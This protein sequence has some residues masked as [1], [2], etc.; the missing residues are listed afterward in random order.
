MSRKMTSNNE[1]LKFGSRILSRSV[2]SFRDRLPEF[3][4]ST[5]TNNDN[6]DN[7]NNND[8]DDD[9]DEDNDKEIDAW[10]D[11]N[12]RSSVLNYNEFH[13]DKI[14]INNDCRNT[15]RRSTKVFDM[16][17]SAEVAAANLKIEQERRREKMASKMKE[18]LRQKYDEV[19]MSNWLASSS[20]ESEN[21]IGINPTNDLHNKKN[22]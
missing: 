5:H 3:I 7:N 17:F 19:E 8:D 14:N 21:L 13:T 4:N 10:F 6:N 16:E 18:R 20:N 1:G 22:S 15:E 11:K 2:S 12:R 9:D